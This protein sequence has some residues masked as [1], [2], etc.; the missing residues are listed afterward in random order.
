MKLNDILNRVDETLDGPPLKF[1]KVSNTLF[2]ID[3]DGDNKIEVR[4]FHKT[5]QQLNCISVLFSSPQN[6][7]PFQLTNFF[8]GPGAIRIFTTISTI[9]E[10]HDPDIVVFIPVGTDVEIENKKTKLYR[11]V[12]RKLQLMGKING[13]EEV[14]L[15]EYDKPIF[16]GTRKKASS[17][18]ID[19]LS[20]IVKQFGIS[21]FM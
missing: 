20:D 18:P 6:T 16:I 17:L 4:L 3:L 12:M 7:D 13:V 2:V 10:P 14:K 8:N 1:N 21:K 15:E 9:L 11:V 19:T 5:I